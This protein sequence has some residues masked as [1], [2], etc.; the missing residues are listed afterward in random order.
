MSAFKLIIQS[1]RNAIA[2]VQFQGQWTDK[3]DSSNQPVVAN[4]Q[5]TLVLE[6]HLT[7]ASAIA[8]LAKVTT[9]TLTKMAKSVADA[10]K[11]DKVTLVTP[12]WVTGNTTWSATAD[13]D[14]RIYRHTKSKSDDSPITFINYK[15][16]KPRKTASFT[17]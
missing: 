10:N 11:G 9:N 8:K 2:R 14:G 15:V 13:K 7:D 12:K 3:K 4:N 16:Y 17:L 5:V 1:V 6:G